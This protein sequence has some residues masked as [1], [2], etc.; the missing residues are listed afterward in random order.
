MLN[1]TNMKKK[2]DSGKSPGDWLKECQFYVFGF[3]YM[4]ARI[5]LNSNATMMPFY[6]ISVSKFNPLPGL[7][8]S[9]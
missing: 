5:A 3:V 6:L 8:T 4:F 1:P 7:E 9:P 2:Q